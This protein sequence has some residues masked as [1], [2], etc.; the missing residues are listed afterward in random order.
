MPTHLYL[1]HVLRNVICK[2]LA[3]DTDSTT[4]TARFANSGA[5]ADDGVSRRPEPVR[6]RMLRS[7]L[8]GL[9]RT[10][11]RVCVA[12]FPASI[13]MTRTLSCGRWKV[14]SWTN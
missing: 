4:L 1:A 6:A 7:G 14:E 11:H 10:P 2:P 5:V 8:P 3:G 13:L 12:T 9:I